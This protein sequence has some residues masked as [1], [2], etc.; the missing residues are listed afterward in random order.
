MKKYNFVVG[1]VDESYPA[2]Q[3]IAERIK[4]VADI[5]HGAY[6][7]YCYGEA[8]TMPR[9]STR[10]NGAAVQEADKECGLFF[11]ALGKVLQGK[12][13]NELEHEVVEYYTDIK[14]GDVEDDTEIDWEDEDDE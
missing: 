4:N 2:A 9:L 7:N 6:I 10:I 13:L 5:W 8:G 12:E 14:L 11:E 3:I 1:D